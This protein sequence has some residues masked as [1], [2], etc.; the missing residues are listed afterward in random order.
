MLSNTESAAAVEEGPVS[1]TLM[2]EDVLHCCSSNDSS[3][4]Q[5]AYK[6]A[7]R[8]HCALCTQSYTLERGKLLSPATSQ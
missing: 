8:A 7:K 5:L 4:E 1:L 3:S 2:L 6:L